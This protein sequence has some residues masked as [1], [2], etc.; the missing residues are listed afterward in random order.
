MKKTTLAFIALACASAAQAQS[1]VQLYGLTDIYVGSMRRSDQAARTSVVNSN[2]MTTSYWGVAGNEDLGGGLRAL[3][4]LESFFQTDTG[5][6]GRNAT[7]PYFSRNAWVG[8][9]GGWGQFSMGRQTNRLFV[10]SGQFDPFGGS[11]Q[12]SPI[13]L[14]SWQAT[15]NR[16][17][18]G[19]S[20]WNN[21]LQYASPN[22][23]GFRV[24]AVYGLGEQ[25]GGGR[26]NASLAVNYASGPFAAALVAQRV[27][28]GPGV[29]G[30]TPAIS[31]Q[32]AF[33]AAA[34]YDFGVAQLFG[35]A[36]RSNI[37]NLS[38]S[39]NTYQL[40]VGVPVSASGKLMASVARTER[41]IAGK[42]GPRRT[43]WALGYDHQLSKRTD[44]YAIYL[45]DKLS[46]YGNAGS[47]GA[48]IRH[49]F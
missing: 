16:A 12:F 17:V 38:S 19:D 14:Q 11:L 34:S 18:L 33:L 42:D 46:G 44:L 47:V 28:Y 4:T 29:D 43:T 9:A 13:M 40:G 25:A 20:V 5:A 23:A 30:V 26:D 41:D 35:Q 45:G 7:D 27:A 10:A 15:Y 8:L 21:T 1:S 37:S 31:K 39:A 49:R 6:M 24:N 32:T 22:L 3:F 48:G 36:Q 2:G